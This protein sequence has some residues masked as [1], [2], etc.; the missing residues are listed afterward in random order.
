MS[1]WLSIGRQ[2]EFELRVP[3]RED[4]SAAAASGDV[5]N[6]GVGQLIAGSA[7]AR[8]AQLAPLLLPPDSVS[9][10]TFNGQNEFKATVIYSI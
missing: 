2:F 1:F 7:R 10:P 6:F 3:S 9:Q 4:R 5:N 8:T